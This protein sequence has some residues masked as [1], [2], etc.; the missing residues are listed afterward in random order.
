MCLVGVPF[1]FAST[2]AASELIARK[3]THVKLAVSRNGSRALLSY[4]AAG[5]HWYVLASGAL[6]ALAP[7][8]G[9]KQVSF[10]L[11]RSTTRPV[12]KGSCPTL[13]V[14]RVK[15]TSV[16]TACT[17]GGVQNWAVQEW[18]RTLPNFGVAPNA[19]KA[20]PELRLSHWTGPL[21]QLVLKSDWSFAGKWQ[22]V[23]GYLVYRGKGVYGFRATR[24]GTPTDSFGRNIYLDTLDSAYGTGWL[25]ESA[26]LTHSPGGTFCYDFVKH[27]AGLTGAGKQYR[28]TVI[29]PGVT[30]DIATV[31]NSAGAYD[32]TRDAVANQDMTSLMPNDRLCR[33]S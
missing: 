2:A 14:H 24:S 29:G 4:T 17:V 19:L 20:M 11:K 5:R 26:F 7:S 30:P 9:K 3:A 22:H 28:G 16:V 25:R 15:I 33:A 18:Q 6:N 12:F 27:R 31:V 10:K 13:S 8:R 23:Y 32:P 21:P 1:V